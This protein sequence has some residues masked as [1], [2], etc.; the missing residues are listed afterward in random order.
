MAKPKK[1]IDWVAIEAAYRAGVEPVT[2][3]AAKHGISH[4][5]INKRAKAKGWV[6]NPGS[7]K[8]AIVE[9]HFSGAAQPVSGDKVSP[10]VSG[11]TIETIQGAANEDIID[12]ERGLRIHR[13]CLINLEVSAEKSS[14]PKEIKIIV[15]AASLAITAIRKIRGLDAPNSADMKDID[16]AIEAELENMERGRQAGAPADAQSA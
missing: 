15:E 6:R 10:Q 9:A 13:H 16:A 12:M 8:R 4:T 14:D 1:D 11:L 2:A 7:A 5:A 3:I